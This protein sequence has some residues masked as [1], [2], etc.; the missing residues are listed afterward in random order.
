MKVET[1]FQDTSERPD[2]VTAKQL[3][4]AVANL[5]TTRPGPGLLKIAVCILLLAPILYLA[6]T[7]ESLTVF[8]FSTL[9]SG[10]VA[11]VLIITTHD[12]I[13]H[14]LTG[15]RWFDEILPRLISWPIIWFHGVYSEVHKLHHKMNG[16][17]IS[18]PE[19]LQWTEQ[20]Y[21][22]ASAP[23]RFY[24][25]HQWF[26]KIFVF[27]GIGFIIE[28]L[29]TGFRFAGKSKAM[30]RALLTDILGILVVNGSIYAI[31][32]NHGEA[33]RWF[34]IWLVLERCAGGVM[35]W[36]AL[37]EHYGLWGKGR[38]YF[39][40]QSYCC[41]N[42]RTNEFASWF[43]NRLNF[44]SVHH[45]FPRVPFY[46]L[47]EAHQRFM[48]LYGKSEV[49]ALVEEAGYLQTSIRLAKRPT[50]IGAVDPASASHRYK[51]VALSDLA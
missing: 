41:R 32:Y 45:A 22:Q 11:S 12:A 29:R 43:F 42:L 6:V 5:Q 9:A 25:R 20:E 40:T 44:H 34:M 35:Q 28:I 15:W 38:H 10:L 51:M 16:D 24:V 23:V 31:A 49:E 48:K 26:F 39:E 7:T 36:R 27:A 4:R 33:G 37:V 46:N 19:R 21:R 14:T 30:R 8:V 2:I 18:D 17:D 50:V 3:Q 47:R 1:S 13:H